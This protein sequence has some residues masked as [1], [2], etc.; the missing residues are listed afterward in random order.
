ML[1]FVGHAVL[2]QR[3]YVLSAGSIAYAAMAG[4]EVEHGIRTG[5]KFPSVLR[6]HQVGVCIRQS[7]E[8]HFAFRL[9]LHAEALAA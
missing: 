9:N 2:R 4:I 7:G 1:L 6:V 5:R 8:G 3:I